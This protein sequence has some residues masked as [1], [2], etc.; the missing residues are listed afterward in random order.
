MTICFW[1]QIKDLQELRN[2]SLEALFQT[3]KKK[4]QGKGERSETSRN[5]QAMTHA[6]ALQVGYKVSGLEDVILK[7]MGDGPISSCF[8]DTSQ[9]RG[10]F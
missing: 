7:K 2:E 9:W 6:D 10:G 8:H 1:S 4:R 3:W 5:V